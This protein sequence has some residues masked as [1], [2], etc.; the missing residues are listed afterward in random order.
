[1]EVEEKLEYKGCDL[2][3]TQLISKKQII[4]FFNY[5]TW[6]KNTM[7]P[8]RKKAPNLPAQA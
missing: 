5:S 3:F 2:T 6:L 1:M 8:F 4:F 7:C